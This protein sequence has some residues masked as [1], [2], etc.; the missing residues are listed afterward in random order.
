MSLRKQNYPIYLITFRESP[1][2][3][4]AIRQLESSGFDF[5]AVDGVSG[6]RLNDG[7]LKRIT[8]ALTGL[9]FPKTG[10]MR[11]GEV[12][13]YLSHMLAHREIAASG[14]KSAVIIE[15]DAVLNTLFFDFQKAE[16][17]VPDTT[18]ICFLASNI[19]PGTRYCKTG[20]LLTHLTGDLS[21]LSVDERAFLCHGI[22]GITGLLPEKAIERFSGIPSDRHELLLS[23]LPCHFQQVRQ[24]SD[25]RTRPGLFH[26]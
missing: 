3:A 15:D 5:H 16:K 24:G 7:L 18:D 12:A 21:I 11:K 14:E 20:S 13:C 22:L 26:Y 19:D 4:A 6:S 25:Y 8:S 17:T 9:L 2:R 23:E 10:R 1:R